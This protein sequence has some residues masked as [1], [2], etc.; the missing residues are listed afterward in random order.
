M[1][2]RTG[3]RKSDD[4]VG[5]Q[6]TPCNEIRINNI[7]EEV[8]YDLCETVHNKKELIKCIKNTENFK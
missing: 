8:G 2:E 4:S 7:A 3:L 6:P 1:K 5:S